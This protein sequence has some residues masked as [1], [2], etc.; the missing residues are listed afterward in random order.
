MGFKGTSLPSK[1]TVKPEPCAVL[2]FV[3]DLSGRSSKLDWETHRR[4][5]CRVPKENEESVSRRAWSMIS[6]SAEIPA[7]LIISQVTGLT[8]S[9]RETKT[10]EWNIKAVLLASE[11]CQNSEESPS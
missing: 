5:W 2:L 3:F 1:E 11:S 4:V 6:S 9:L 8:S 10:S 7:L